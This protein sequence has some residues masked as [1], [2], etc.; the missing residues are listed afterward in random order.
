M[1]LYIIISFFLFLV[2]NVNK[3][4]NVE[5]NSESKFWKELSKR[6]F[7]KSHDFNSNTYKYDDEIKIIDSVLIINPINIS[8]IRLKV[9]L[10]SREYQY[11]KGRIELTK[12]I[13]LL[14]KYY[15]FY[16]TRGGINEI[17]KNI[18]QSKRDYETA[19]NLL[20][21][22]INTS[23]S[24]L[25]KLE[26]IKKK[27]ILG[28][29]LYKQKN[30]VLN[31]YDSLTNDNLLNKKIALYNRSIIEKISRNNF[32]NDCK[33]GSIYQINKNDLRF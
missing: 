13:K 14:P 3:G 24:N 33:V 10:L 1:K 4:Q 8:A 17:L 23:N 6:I 11:E 12:R 25:Y 19:N 5:E 21:T 16:M 9:Q 31:E 22:E 20:I 18:N 27:S 32:I 15:E 30:I 7:F 2:P 28:L 26:L 29:L